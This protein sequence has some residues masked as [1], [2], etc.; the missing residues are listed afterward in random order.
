MGRNAPRMVE[1]AATVKDGRP[2]HDVPSYTLCDAGQL[3]SN[4]M[5]ET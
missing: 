1:A 5:A 2:R 3:L 4:G